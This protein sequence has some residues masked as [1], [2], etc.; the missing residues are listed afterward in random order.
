M[1][2]HLTK[3]KPLQEKNMT[4]LLTAN[5]PRNEQS[6]FGGRVKLTGHPRLSGTAADG[7]R[8]SRACEL[9]ESLLGLQDIF[10]IFGV[11]NVPRIAVVIHYNLDCHRYTPGC[12][13]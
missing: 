4:A 5:E 8:E 13:A 7:R 12:P 1:H 3:P 11:E 9:F 6:L 2:R 10:R